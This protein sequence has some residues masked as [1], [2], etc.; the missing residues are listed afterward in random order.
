[1][2]KK[3]KYLWQFGAILMLPVADRKKWQKNVL[4]IFDN[5]ARMA[6]VMKFRHIPHGEIGKWSLP[7]RF[8]LC[9]S[10]QL[11]GDMS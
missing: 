1:M 5:V 3:S 9:Y 7:I 10:N 2:A 11:S 4:I 6:T 8:V